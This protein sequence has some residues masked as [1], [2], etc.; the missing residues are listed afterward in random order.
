HILP[1]A[2]ERVGQRTCTRT[3]GNKHEHP[4][5]DRYMQQQRRR[6][7]VQGMGVVDEKQRGPCADFGARDERVGRQ[8]ERALVRYVAE[9]RG[10]QERSE[11]TERNRRSGSRRRNSD[12]S[13]A[14]VQSDLTGEPRL[15]NARRAAQNDTTR[16]RIAPQ[17][18][19]VLEFSLAA[20]ERP[21][22]LHPDRC[23]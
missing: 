5:I 10:R 3:E 23:R 11:S 4:P 15:A 8:S 17:P 12:N 22:R 9:A 19:K 7:V 6:R 18:M 13:A 14:A 16:L 2:L 1:E 20:N 21:P